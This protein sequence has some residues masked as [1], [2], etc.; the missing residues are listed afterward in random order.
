MK[1]LI[2]KLKT[3]QIEGFEEVTIHDVLFWIHQI[4]LEERVK[5]LKLDN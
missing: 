2:K 4:Q 3:L 1:E 5:R